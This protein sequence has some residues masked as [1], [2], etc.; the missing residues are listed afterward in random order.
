MKGGNAGTRGKT[1]G[2]RF[3]FQDEYCT[4]DFIC[5]DKVHFKVGKDGA[6]LTILCSV[7]DS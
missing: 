5:V 7:M 1:E 2:E 3:N 6:F 4:C